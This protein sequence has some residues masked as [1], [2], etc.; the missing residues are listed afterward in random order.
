MYYIDE[1]DDFVNEKD[2]GYASNVLL[3]ETVQTLTADESI[4]FIYYIYII[5]KI[6][7]TFL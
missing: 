1:T 4:K 2:N 5:A 6:M 7:P 3:K